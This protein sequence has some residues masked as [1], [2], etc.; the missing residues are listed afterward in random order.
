[1]SNAALVVETSLTNA[2]GTN[3]IVAATSSLPCLGKTA[4]SRR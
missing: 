1:M 4:A 3:A 2:A